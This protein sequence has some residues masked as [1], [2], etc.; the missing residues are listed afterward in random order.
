MPWSKVRGIKFHTRCSVR[1]LI[2]GGSVNMPRRIL[3][4]Q[5]GGHGYYVYF[6]S[7]IF[8]FYSVNVSTGGGEPEAKSRV[9]L[10][11]VRLAQTG[12]T[13]E[14]VAPTSTLDSI[15]CGISANNP[16][17]LQLVKF[18]KKWIVVRSRNGLRGQPVQKQ[19]MGKKWA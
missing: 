3:T 10:D 6:A 7:V 5:P 14:Q 8:N 11:L 13:G 17:I 19:F 9:F 4:W 18:S 15:E 1:V 2:T 12:S 16:R